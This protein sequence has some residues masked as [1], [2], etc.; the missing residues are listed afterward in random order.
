MSAC[1]FKVCQEKTK[2]NFDQT[3]GNNNLIY[4]R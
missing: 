2:A 1:S 3:A 4:K